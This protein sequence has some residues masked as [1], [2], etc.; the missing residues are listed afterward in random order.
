MIRITT[1]IAAIAPVEM[2][3]FEAV[4]EAALVGVEVWV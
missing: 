4:A 3:L 2:L 1:A